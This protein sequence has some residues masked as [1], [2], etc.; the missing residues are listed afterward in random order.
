MVSGDVRI[1]NHQIAAALP[2]D[3]ERAA[4]KKG[5]RATGIGAGDDMDLEGADRR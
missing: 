2:A 1:G 5:E 3:D 4:G